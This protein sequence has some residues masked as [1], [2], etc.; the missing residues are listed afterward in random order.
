[1]GAQREQILMRI[2]IRMRANDRRAVLIEAH[3]LVYQQP[4]R[5]KKRRP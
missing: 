4:Q 2:K 1:M 3:R 5:P